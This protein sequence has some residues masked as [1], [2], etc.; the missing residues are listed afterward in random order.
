LP[1][2][3]RAAGD[4]PNP[5]YAPWYGVPLKSARV[6]VAVINM[7]QQES[8]VS[9]LSFADITKRLA[10]VPPGSHTFI[11]KRVSERQLQEA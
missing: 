2:A 10:E 4:R 5:E 3:A 9:R 6:A 1:A 11:S 7:L 8:R